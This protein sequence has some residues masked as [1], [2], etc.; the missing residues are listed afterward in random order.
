MDNTPQGSV[1]GPVIV[2]EI[3]PLDFYFYEILSFKSDSLNPHRPK[4]D[5]ACLTIKGHFHA[6]FL[7]KNDENTLSP[8]GKWF[9][10]KYS[11]ASD[12]SAHH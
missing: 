12:N 1:Q 6:S 2:L 7:K 9:F 10:F 11:Q 5:L 3:H 4:S 8:A